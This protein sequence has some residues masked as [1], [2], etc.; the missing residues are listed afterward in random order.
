M[1]RPLTVERATV[2]TSRFSLPIRNANERVRRRN[3]NMNSIQLLSE[4]AGKIGQKCSVSVS[5]GNT[6]SGYYRGFCESTREYP[7]TLRLGIS[8]DEATKIGTPWLREIGVPYDV[9]LN[10]QF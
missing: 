2:Q 1:R 9:I 7:L 6:Y 5:T 10:I 3:N 4:T 8:E